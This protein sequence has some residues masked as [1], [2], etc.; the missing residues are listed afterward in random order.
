MYPAYMCLSESVVLSVSPFITYFWHNSCVD[1][2][3]YPFATHM[4][5]NEETAKFSLLISNKQRADKYG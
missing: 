1:M 5:V 3:L 4:K 2:H